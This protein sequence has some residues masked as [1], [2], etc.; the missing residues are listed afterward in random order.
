MATKRLGNRADSVSSRPAG[1]AQPNG[2]KRRRSHGEGTLYRRADGR[3]C[4]QLAVVLPDGRLV[5]RTVYGK[6]QREAR[7][8]LDQLRAQLAGGTLPVSARA[9]VGA[10]C[11]AWLDANRS[12]LRPKT[13][14]SYEQLIRLYIVPHFARAKLERLTPTD[15]ERWL[16]KLEASGLAPRTVQ[17]ARTVFGRILRDAERDGLVARNP[18]RLARPV[19]VPPPTVTPWSADEARRFLAAAD[20][21]WLA[22]LYQLLLATGLRIGEALGLSWEDVDLEDRS[23]TVRFQLQRVGGQ[24]LRLPPKSKQSRRTLPLADL[25]VE[26]LARQ[27]ARQ[28]EWRQSPGWVGNPWSLVFT[29]TVGTPLDQRNVHRTFVQLATRAGVPV[30]RLHDLRHAAATLLLESGVDLKVV[31]ALLGHSQLSVTADYYA[32]V[33]HRLAEGA[34][35]KLDDLLRLP[36]Q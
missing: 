5:R 36:L 4:A 22:P 7:E 29:T 21:H 13:V 34:V 23:L 32:H 11:Q 15:V 6:S 1:A 2:R 18:V 17:R 24:W 26:A 35:R 19:S 30:V 12:R 33:T 9:T 10:F 27:R 20:P 28:A 25:A 8:K 14:R 16:G 31:S 3:W